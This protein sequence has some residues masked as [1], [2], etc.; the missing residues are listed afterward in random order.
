MWQ[1]SGAWGGSSSGQ[2]TYLY[3]SGVET[4]YFKYTIDGD[5]LTVTIK[6]DSLGATVTGIRL[7]GIGTTGAGIIVTKNEEIT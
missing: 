1:R 5:L 2:S 4:N 7:N 3:G 6:G